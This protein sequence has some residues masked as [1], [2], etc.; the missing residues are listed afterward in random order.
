MKLKTDINTTRSFN[1]SNWI[2]KTIIGETHT[3]ILCDVDII[4]IRK[5]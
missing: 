2:Y 3:P 5:R 1:K 4:F